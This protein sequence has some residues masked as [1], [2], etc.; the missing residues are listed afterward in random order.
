MTD[1]C[2]AIPPAIASAPVLD[3]HLSDAQRALRER[4]RAFADEAIRPRVGR[5]DETYADGQVAHDILTE[6]ARRGILALPV[7]EALG[8]EG[9]NN[10][11]CV[12]ALEE[13]G[14]ADGGIATAVGASWF[15]QTP[16]LMAASPDLRDAWLRRCADRERPFLVC[17]AMT[18]PT[19]GAAIEDPHLK[20][21]TVETE[22]RF[23]A[24]ELLIRGRKLWPSNFDVASLYTV[25]A[26]TDRHAGESGSCLVVVERD[27]PGVS[28]GPPVRKM[29]MSGDR[30]GEILLE[31]VRVPSSHLLGRPG[32]GM[33][34]L[35]R[36][37]A[38]NR[39][40]AAAIAIGI[41][42]AA[43]ETALGWLAHRGAGDALL[44]DHPVVRYLVGEAAGQ[45]DAARLLTWRAA[46]LNTQP[47]S[48]SLHH[49]SMAKVY[50]SDTAM[51]VTTRA[52]QLMG[53]RGYSVDG[54]VEK[55]MR[56]TKIIQI[57][58]GPNELV[59]QEVGEGT[60]RQLHAMFA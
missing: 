31:D 5:I 50:A 8:G 11:D 32:E 7:P 25:V 15:G 21:G 24:D 13:L 42:R 30:N 43:L 52:V 19:G 57:Y 1:C 49:A 18:E 6:A 22:V 36:T 14:A 29:G 37:L 45:L 17:M 26:T 9:G 38:Y 44:V 53:S 20:M 2:Q 59:Q 56:D 16:I 41:A 47:N 51:E 23:Q 27:R 46:W 54:G 34:I 33:G 4:V 55:Y 3:F 35:Q 28:V 58:I 40:G 48:R 12:L 60:A 10:V 39:V